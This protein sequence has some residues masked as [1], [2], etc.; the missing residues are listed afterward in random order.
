MRAQEFTQHLQD[1]VIFDIDDTLLHT[2]ARIRVVDSNGRVLR[3][4]TN[5]E[6]NNY[7]L[8]P[9]ETFDF[10]EF[11]SAEKFQRESQPI[12]P[13]IRKLKTILN[14]SGR[15]RVI[16]LTA[17]AD[18][19]DKEKFLQTFR[20]LGIDMSRIHVH[21]AGNLP[22]DEPPAQ[23][24]AVWVRRY[25]DTGR[26]GHVRLYDD[27]MSNLRVFRSLKNEYPDV[28]FRAIY[29]G[30]RGDTA[31]INENKSSGIS[32]IVQD[33]VSSGIGK[34]YQKHDCK[35]VT[36]AFV[37]WA[38]TNNI[39]TQVL[40]LA[41]PHPDVIKKRP[42]LRGKSGEGDGHIMPVV[43]G[44]ALD[45]T[46]RQFPGQ[47]GYVYSNPLVTP[48]GEVST[49][50]KKIGGYFTYA[51]NWF[52]VN[53]KPATH[54]LGPLESIPSDI[55]NQN[56]GDEL[57]EGRRR[58][59]KKAKF[60]YS[61]PGY[62]GGYYGSSEQSGG[63][64]GVAEGR[65]NEFAPRRNNGDN[66]SPRWYNDQEIAAIVGRGW[67]N[68]LGAKLNSDEFDYP[69]LMHNPFF[70]DMQQEEMIDLAQD[71]L[72]DHGYKVRINDL[73]NNKDFNN[74]DW[75]IRGNFV[76]PDNNVSEGWSKKYKRSIDCS[77][78]RGFSQRAH[79]QGRKKK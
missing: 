7:Q 51:P 2:T 67:I 19:D 14:H 31:T 75:L 22:G 18:F 8:Q 49:V 26:Y 23:K 11:R 38:S 66:N 29:V 30:P 78:P 43:G 70:N 61:G 44:Y 69:E 17:R 25:L 40:S 48:I 72:E 56:F 32:K 46:A 33:F 57:L 60:A 50:Y 59:K 20:D 45:F 16:M 64:G 41:P 4:L 73:R 58:N 9:G 24:K 76:N 55:F 54:Y 21:R 65:L 10:G 62:W 35:T 74:R 34:K 36:R 39:S 52:I 15:A 71:W 79:C 68:E 6:F 3:E 1:L 63:E 28:D 53:G 5:Q 12:E 77:R 13:M 47:A 27:S 37:K 42:E